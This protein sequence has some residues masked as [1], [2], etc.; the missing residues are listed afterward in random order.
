MCENLF[1]WLCVGQDTRMQL[2]SATLLVRLCGSQPWWGQFLAETVANL[3]S[4]NNSAVFPQDRYKFACF[5][6]VYLSIYLSYLIKVIL[7][8]IL[9]C[10]FQSLHYFSLSRP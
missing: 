1:Y 3:F 8:L 7:I 4:S 10:I 5:S 2:A 6:V 9:I